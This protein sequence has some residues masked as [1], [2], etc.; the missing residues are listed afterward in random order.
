M[1]RRKKTFQ[2]GVK[3]K[4]IK[5]ITSSMN[6]DNEKKHNCQETQII[7]MCIALKQACQTGG[8]QAKC[9]LIACPMRPAAILLDLKIT[10]IK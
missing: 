8:P 9:G 10:L 5:K 3:V 6:K 4:N 2:I 1:S 7:C